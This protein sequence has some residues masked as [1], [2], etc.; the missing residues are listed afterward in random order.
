MTEKIEIDPLFAGTAFFKTEDF[1]IETPGSGQI[2][3]RYSQVKRGELH[4]I[5]L[6]L[7]GD[8]AEFSAMIFD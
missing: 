1:A 5:R 3:N 2:V 8:E 4:R 7:S 6:G